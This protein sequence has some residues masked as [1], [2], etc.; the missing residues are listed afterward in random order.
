MGIR[1]VLLDAGHTLLEG[2]PSWFDI[3][4]EALAAF[5]VALDRE[6]LQRAYARASDLF[7]PLAPDQI[8]PEVERRF[9]RE[10][11]AHLQ[12]P[13]R[14]EEL[15]ERM[16]RILAEV[17]PEYTPYPEVPRVLEELRRRGYRLGVVSNWEPDLPDVLRRVGLLDAFEVVVA[18]A[19]VG[20]AKPDPRIFRVALD[21][22][23]LEPHLSV[24]VGD[25]YEAD[26]QG[27]RAAGIHPVLLDRD[28]VYQH[29]DVPLIRTLEELL[30]LLEKHASGGGNDG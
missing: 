6:A 27:A 10:M 13:G 29:S 26:V 11:I 4:E 8:N 3:W 30:P 9:L 17:R 22:L 18:S 5:D 14:E 16:H 23:R 7:A 21:A 1:A 25:S 20:A 12:V 2:R 28:Y 24:H 19:V 15:A